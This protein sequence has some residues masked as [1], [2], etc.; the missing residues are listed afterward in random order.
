MF[1]REMDPAAGCRMGTPPTVLVGTVLGVFD[2]AVC[3]LLAQVIPRGGATGA[4]NGGEVD[5]HGRSRPGGLSFLTHRVRL[6]TDLGH[7]KVV[8][9][10]EFNR[11]LQVVEF[12]GNRV[13]DG[14]ALLDLL[15]LAFQERIVG[16]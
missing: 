7:S 14:A 4:C 12:I 6:P 5:P 1:G 8:G 15:H 9:R 10:D 11:R 2:R 13:L 16:K 3:G